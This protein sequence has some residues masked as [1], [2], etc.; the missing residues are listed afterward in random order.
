MSLL[1]GRFGLPV[2]PANVASV[3]ACSVISF[4]LADRIA[5]DLDVTPA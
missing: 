3:A 5:F 2:A 4:F 1:V